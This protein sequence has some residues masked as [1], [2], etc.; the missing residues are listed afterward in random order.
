MSALEAST[1]FMGSALGGGVRSLT[2]APDSRRWH[3]PVPFFQDDL[4]GIS[5]GYKAKARRLKEYMDTV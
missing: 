3:L 5:L 1:S 2:H 4:L